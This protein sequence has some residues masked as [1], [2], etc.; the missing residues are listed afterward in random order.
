MIFKTCVLCC[1]VLVNVNGADFGRR[2]GLLEDFNRMDKEIYKEVKDKFLHTRIGK[3]LKQVDNSIENAI[4]GAYKD[5]SEQYSRLQYKDIARNLRE[6]HAV[7]VVSNMVEKYAKIMATVKKYNKKEIFAM[8]EDLIIQY[9][10]QKEENSGEK[11]FSSFN[12]YLS[13]YIERLSNDI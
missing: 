13:D 4:S 5:I 10:D 2:D 7:N 8:L 3:S 1:F 6:K 12:E 9:Q 11:S